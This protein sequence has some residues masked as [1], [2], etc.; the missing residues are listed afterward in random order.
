MLKTHNCGELRPTNVGQD[1]TLAGWV[2]RRR[3]QGGLI[4]I[5]LRDR[6]GITQVRIDQE[7]QPEAHAIASGLR[8]E[9]VVQV[10]GK[11]AL[12]P[13]GTTNPQLITGEVEVIPDSLTILNAAKT[14]PFLINRDEFI[15]EEARMR[16][17]YLYLRRPNVQEKLV[18]RHRIV[19]FIRDYL[20]ERGLV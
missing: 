12:R 6:W 3:D 17:R 5:D 15:E 8:S 11:V 16:Y 18:L 13:V 14:P 1:V 9:F 7:N 19:K 4:F 10:R 2:H 20:D